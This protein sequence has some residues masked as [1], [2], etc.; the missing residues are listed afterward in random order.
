MGRNFRSPCRLLWDLYTVHMLL[1][2]AIFTLEEKIND[3]KIIGLY[4]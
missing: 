3:E 4:N 1:P 2:L